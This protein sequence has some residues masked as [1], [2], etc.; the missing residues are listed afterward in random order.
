VRIA[1]VFP[2]QASHRPGAL[3]PWRGHP[4][5]AVLDEVRRGSGRD[6]AAFPDDP[7]SAPRTADAQS[8]VLAASL[9]AW[10]GLVDAGVHPAVVAG[11]GLGEVTAA[12]AAGVLSVRD[13]AALVATRGAA[14]A[15][16]CERRAG[17]MWAVLRLG[18][19]AV[20]VIV[21]GIDGVVI[22]NDDAPGQ[23]VV[24][25]PPQAL[26]QLREVVRFAGGRVVPL[27]AEGAFH[28]PAMTAATPH[29]A[30]T[31]A[32]LRV[33]H[34]RLPVVSGSTAMPLRT[35]ADVEDALVAGLAAPVRWREVQARLVALGVTDLVEVGPGGVLAGLAD[36]AA[37][38]LRTHSVAAPD[39]LA[40]VLDRLVPLRVA[41]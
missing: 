38:E 12:V 3:E 2:G 21:D 26:T 5:S 31:L 37:P 18:R 35:G 7:G 15:A 30:A 28:S 13:G 20:E 19:D 41:V 14:M 4:A 27:S 25:G 6:V 39:D 1:F 11:H 34:P 17:A 9:V 8:A 40:A 22:A 32:R 16:V 10:R 23:V 24:A 29:L 36:R 33:H